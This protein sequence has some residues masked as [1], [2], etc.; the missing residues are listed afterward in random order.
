MSVRNID[1][2]KNWWVKV[3]RRTGYLQGL[4]K[5]PHKI[6]SKNGGN[7]NFTMEKPDNHQNSRLT[8]SEMELVNIMC[9]ELHWEERH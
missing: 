4:G 7:F 5:S 6:F 2:Y 8:T 3:G 9:N 1:E